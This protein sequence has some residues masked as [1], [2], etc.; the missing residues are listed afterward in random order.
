MIFLN[1]SLQGNI[2]LTSIVNRYKADLI[3][4]SRF[5][6]DIRPVLYF[7][8]VMGNKLITIL[9][10]FL[11]NTTFS[12][13]YCCYCLFNRKNLNFDILRSYKWGQHAEILTY[14]SKNSKNIFET[15]VNYNARKY[16]EGKKI[17]FYNVIEVIYW[18]ILTR[19]KTFF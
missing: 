15:S 10:N 4:G 16:N 7:W 11:N 1:L 6:S 3:M 5:I 17:R 19:I 8:H 9:F 18:I 2:E 13:I 12:D 14:L